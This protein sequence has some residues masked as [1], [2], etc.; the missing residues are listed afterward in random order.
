MSSDQASTQIILLRVTKYSESDLIVMGLT[1]DHGKMSLIARGALRSKKRFSGGLLEATHALKIEYKKSIRGQGLMTLIEAELNEDFSGL[2]SDFDRLQT[3][4][5][6]VEVVGRISQEGDPHSQDLYHLTGHSLRALQ[7]AKDLSQFWTHFILRLLL[8]Q[9][10][11]VQESW[12]QPYLESPMAHHSS[13]EAHGAGSMGT[14]AQ[15]VHNR[16]QRALDRYL[17]SCS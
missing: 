16:A 15:D 12:M 13:L 8:N 5:R 3:A 17:E 2:R 1:P 11:L 10:I 9:G 14:M 4:L 6:L 7:R